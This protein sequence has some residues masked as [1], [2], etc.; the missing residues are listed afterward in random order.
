MVGKQISFEF[1]TD[2]AASNDIAQHISKSEETIVKVVGDVAEA[3][4]NNTTGGALSNPLL[5]ELQIKGKELEIK[6]KEFD[7]LKSWA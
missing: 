4:L 6:E 1:I 2:W 7:L 5:L 3:M